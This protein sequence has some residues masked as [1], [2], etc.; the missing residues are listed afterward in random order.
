MEEQCVFVGALVDVGGGAMRERERRY[1]TLW[2]KTIMTARRFVGTEVVGAEV[3]G[4]TLCEQVRW[5]RW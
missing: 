1:R 5:R 4:D 2:E 3:G